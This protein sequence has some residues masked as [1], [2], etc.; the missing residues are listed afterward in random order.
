MDG[1]DGFQQQSDPFTKFW[2]EFMANS[3]MAGMMPPSAGAREDMMKKMRAAFFQSWGKY[4]EDFM[5]SEQ[6]L[7]LMKQQ[8]DNALTMRS[9]INDF[10]AK[11]AD[12]SPM[13]AKSDTEAIVLAIKS[14]DQ[15]VGKQLAELSQ[16]VSALENGQAN[17]AADRKPAKEG[18]A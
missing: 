1:F 9:Q 14:M 7:Q 11:A 17:T 18:N 13:A 2:T 16:R 15:R 8:M 5:A 12:Q 6:F 3:P 4:C 10:L